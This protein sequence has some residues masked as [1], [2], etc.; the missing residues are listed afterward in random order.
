MES[1]T[2]KLNAR[3][4][5]QQARHLGLD[6]NWTETDANS[7]RNRKRGSDGKPIQVGAHVLSVLNKSDLVYFVTVNG[8]PVAAE[9]AVRDMSLV[10]TREVANC[11]GYPVK[12]K[13]RREYLLY[14]PPSLA[15]KTVVFFVRSVP[16]RRVALAKRSRRN[17][18]IRRRSFRNCRS[19]RN[20]RRRGAQEETEE[21]Q[22]RLRRRQQYDGGSRRPTHY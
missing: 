14:D 20:G 19:A 8:H 3:F 2:I 1:R 13:A 7:Y 15:I 16:G 21:K 5:R 6:A 11:L 17:L 10:T 9:T 22:R 12:V 18:D 4:Y